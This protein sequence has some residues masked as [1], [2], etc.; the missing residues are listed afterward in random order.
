MSKKQTELEGFKRPSIPEL[1]AVI[2]EYLDARANHADATE[3]I[4][5]VKAKAMNLME[6][7]SDSLAKDEDG[8][9]HY[10]YSDGEFRFDS[11]WRQAQ[12]EEFKVKTLGVEA[13][14]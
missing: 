11:V 7:H 1:D 5:E 9:S 6:Q 14:D 10:L 13:D 12:K 3:R 4:K 2:G 8:A